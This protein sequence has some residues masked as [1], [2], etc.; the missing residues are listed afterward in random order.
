M[1]TSVSPDYVSEYWQICW[2]HSSAPLYFLSLNIVGHALWNDLFVV[3]V[4][5]IVLCRTY[6]TVHLMDW[7]EGIRVKSH[8]GGC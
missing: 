4:L 3:T 7:G 2:V 6:G 5:E 8:Q 1:I